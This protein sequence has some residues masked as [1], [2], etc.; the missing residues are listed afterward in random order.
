MFLQSYIRLLCLRS[1][2]DNECKGKTLKTG[3]RKV[4]NHQLM[5]QLA[6][7]SEEIPSPQYRSRRSERVMESSLV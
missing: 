4:Q 3:F 1:R 5:V 6:L 7:Y 2:F